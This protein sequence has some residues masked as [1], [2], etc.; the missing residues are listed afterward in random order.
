MFS[1]TGCGGSTSAISGDAFNNVSAQPSQPN[2]MDTPT[3]VAPWYPS[4]FQEL[5]PNVAIKPFEPGSIDCGY[6]SA[7]TCVQI[8][9]VTN[10]TCSL[11]FSMNFENDGVVIDNGIDSANVR[12]GEVAVLSF[13]SF[14]M[15]RYSG[16]T[17]WRPTEVN[18]Y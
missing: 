10:K 3:A 17:S 8:Y 12:S 5:T 2:E 7:H 6:S 11:F 1:L 14:D 15:A 9:V 18:C 13:V 16:K 4:D